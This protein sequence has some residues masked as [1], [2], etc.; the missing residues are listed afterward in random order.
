[1]LTGVSYIRAYFQ[2]SPGVS[3]GLTPK[4]VEFAVKK[5]RS[6][7]RIGAAVMMSLEMLNDEQAVL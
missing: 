4:Q 5:Y 1:M 7:R 2:S 6:H 3:K